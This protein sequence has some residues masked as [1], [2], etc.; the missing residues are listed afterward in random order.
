MMQTETLGP[1]T[2]GLNLTSNRDLSVFLNNSE[3]GEATNVVFTNEGFVEPRPGCKMFY[4]LDSTNSLYEHITAGDGE[5]NIIGRV[6]NSTGVWALITATWGSNQSSLF[7]V[8]TR[9]LGVEGLNISDVQKL[10]DYSGHK[11]THAIVHSGFT[12][13]INTGTVPNN[14]YYEKDNGVLLFTDTAT[15]GYIYP[16]ELPVNAA[17]YM[18]PTL[19]V[20]A[21]HMGMVV[22]DRLFLF[23]KV[24]NKMYWGPPQYI[25]DFRTDANTVTYGPFGEDTAGE[26]NIEPTY[27]KDTIRNIAFYNNNFYIFKPFKTYM[28]TYQLNP[29]TDGY[30]RK[31]SNETGAFDCCVLKDQIVVINNKGIFKMEGTEFIDLQA[32]MN[33]RFE[34]PLDHSNV[35]PDDVFITAWNQNILFGLRDKITTP[36]TT[37][38]HHYNINAQTGAWSKWD[39]S[40]L[41]DIAT[42]GSESVFVQDVN[43]TFGALLF[44]TF[45]KKKLVYMYWKPDPALWEYHLDS[46]TTSVNVKPTTYYFPNVVIKTAASFGGSMI[47]YKKLYRYFIRF[48]LSEVPSNPIEDPVWTLSINYN[49]YRFDDTMNP[50]FGL[51]PTSTEPYP[52]PLAYGTPTTVYKR[53]YQIILPQQRAREFVFELKRRATTFSLS[54]VGGL[55][56]N[57]PDTDRPIKAGYFFALSGLWVHYEDKALI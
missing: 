1:W 31:I 15:V 8:K 11:I 20:P 37:K 39:Y 25:L 30:M 9:T 42:P 17:T 5:L 50:I 33:F 4:D 56:I 16:H 53:V 54:G 19:L 49:D 48:Y 27:T 45:D 36:G 12:T 41:P 57:N 40:Y 28:F 32:K 52:S 55:S 6:T 47:N 29:T 18:Q 10:F 7:K 24:K 46:D 2:G 23:D 44:M 14:Y 22:K 3:L 35:T 38:Y 26:E 21:S 13:T 51:Y 43:T 34:I